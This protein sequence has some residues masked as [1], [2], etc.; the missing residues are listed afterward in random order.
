M[1]SRMLLLFY[2]ANVRTFYSVMPIQLAS[3][4][5]VSTA[6][7]TVMMNFITC[8][9]IVFLSINYLLSE[10]LTLKIDSYFFR[11]Q[12]AQITQIFFFSEHESHK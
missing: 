1:A 2:S 7:S 10:N 11:T 6:D 4:K 3:P 8:T 12:I 5:V 9:I